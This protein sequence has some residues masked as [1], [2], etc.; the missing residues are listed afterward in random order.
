[1][2]CTLSADDSWLLALAPLFLGTRALGSSGSPC[3][4][5][6][7]LFSLFTEV[8]SFLSFFFFPSCFKFPSSRFLTRNQELKQ[9][10]SN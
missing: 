8:V 5:C 4:L 3:W 7:P 2:E 1:M 10:K 9:N 6:F